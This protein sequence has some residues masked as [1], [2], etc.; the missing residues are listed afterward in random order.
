MR[1]HAPLLHFPTTTLFVDDSRSFLENLSLQLDSSLAFRY[2]DSA[3]QALDYLNDDARLSTSLE[4]VFAE[5]EDQDEWPQSKLAVDLKLDHILREAQ[6]LDRFERVSVVVVD[7]DMPEMDGLELCRRIAD[8]AIKKILLTGKADEKVA[9]RAFNQ[10]LIDRFILKQDIQAIPELNQAI[11]ELQQAYFEQLTQTVREAVPA[12]SY[13]FLRDPAF[14]AELE[15][16]CA[17]LGA[18]ERYLH[19]APA[20]YLLRDGQGKEYL[21]LVKTDEELQSHREIA[22]DLGAPEELL[23][24]LRGK[25]FVPYFATENGE[26]QPGGAHWQSCLLPA[27]TIAGRELWH[28]AIAFETSAL[29]IKGRGAYHAF[30]DRLDQQQ[31]DH[32]F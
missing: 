1:H 27:A 8:P 32:R 7:F 12:K 26:Y 23:A 3:H 4:A 13:R 10:G 24:H 9:V 2:F 22:E 15:K 18:V 17:Q 6:N 31:R 5:Q 14:A 28:Y 21:L 25:Q 11:A 16:I 30:L 19:A 29:P 20:G